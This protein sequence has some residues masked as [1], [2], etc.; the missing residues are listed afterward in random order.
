MRFFAKFIQLASFSW[1]PDRRQKSEEKIRIIAWGENISNLQSG[2]NLIWLF[3]FDLI[4]IKIREFDLLSKEIGFEKI[5]MEK[6][7]YLNPI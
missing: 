4:V 2:S 3:V 1:Q 7:K 5:K 6:F